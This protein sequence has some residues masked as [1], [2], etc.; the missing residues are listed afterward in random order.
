M[1]LQGVLRFF[2]LL[3]SP[4]RHLSAN[5]V[6]RSIFLIS[7][8]LVVGI[9]SEKI[10]QTPLQI[11]SIKSQGDVVFA[12]SPTPTMYVSPTPT[13]VKKT[14]TTPRPEA[15]GPLDETEQWGVAKQLS[16]H[17][18]T[19]KVGDD[20][21]I[22]TSQ[23]VLDALN[24]YRERHGSSR[25]SWDDKLGTY[26]QE[27]A[28]YFAREGKLDSHAGF[29]DFISNQDGFVK[30]GF[31]RVGENSSYGYRVSGVHLIEWVYAGD[32]PHNDNQLRTDWTHVG[33]GISATATDLVFGGR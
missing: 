14:Y 3:L 13:S 20:E 17:T 24:N 22:G 16:E 25:L 27:R 9:L 28:D 30:L 12:I 26:A 33:V 29:S 32:G 21:K 19:M 15:D 10:H 6:E 2:A 4:F 8:V 31:N 23:E 7:L 5:R 18:W 11:G 1:L